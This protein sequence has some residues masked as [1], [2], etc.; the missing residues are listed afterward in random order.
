MLAKP[1]LDSSINASASAVTTDFYRRL[2]SPSKREQHYVSFGRWISGGFGGVM[3]MLALVIHFTRTET[4][5]DLQATLISVMSGGLL[6]LFLLGF[7]TKR[8]DSKSASIATIW[9]V[10]GVFFDSEI[11][12][13]FSPGISHILPDKFWIIVLA[14]S[15][16]FLL[17]IGISC[18]SG[19]RALRDLT[20]L[21]VWT[22]NSANQ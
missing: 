16:L 12:R 14:N 5:Q 7:L 17:G 9:T 4:L 19:R 1:T 3:I 10:L 22:R 6:G 18:L 21:T 20:D 8:V 2:I 15:F 13:Q 11:G